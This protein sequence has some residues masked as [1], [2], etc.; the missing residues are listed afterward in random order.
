MDGS[1]GLRAFTIFLALF[2]AAGG[3]C[4]LAGGVCAQA[5]GACAPAASTGAT[6]AEPAAPAL[7]I[8]G[9]KVVLDPSKPAV[10]ATVVVR[11]DG[12]I[13]A[14]GAEVAVP[15]GVTV[16]DASGRTI[17]PAFLDAGNGGLFDPASWAAGPTGPGDRAA[18]MLG[19]CEPR[20]R[21]RLIS[22]GIAAVYTE[23]PPRP[24]GKG[25]TGALAVA[26][27]AP[28]IPDLRDRMAGVTFALGGRVRNETSLLSRKA[29]RTNV[30]SALDGA[31]RYRESW[32]K[33]EKEKEDHEK[34][35]KEWEE[36]QK[37]A[38]G[39]PKPDEKKAEEKKPEEGAPAGGSA[40]DRMRRAAE[41]RRAARGEEKKD[42]AAAGGAAGA[43]GSAGAGNA[44]NEKPKP[45]LP[46]AVDPAHEAVLRV[47]D[48][49]VPIRIEAHWKEDIL[50]ACE[51]AVSRNLR[52]TLLGATEALEVLDKVKEA[53]AT[54]VLPPPVVLGADPLERFNHRND[55]AAAL[56]RAG[57]P[58][59]F[60]TAGAGG[61][62]FDAVPLAA[63]LAVSFGLPEAAALRALTSGAARALGVESDFGALAPGRFAALQIL[64]GAPLQ[65]GTEVEKLVLGT[66][67]IDP[68]E[69]AR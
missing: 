6:A 26:D 12:R 33:F 67:A 14:V 34:K 57:V 24:G 46:P 58:V 15:A 29:A 42:G 68:R 18:D 52:L 64:N 61:W 62:R 10:E 16:I 23:M 8:T 44:G 65:P 35:L 56:D 37:G 13:A 36:K 31:K 49:K 11:A 9:G 51:L 47:L 66:K 69:E 28:A 38:G 54:V 48:R 63:R 19:A 22:A 3:V 4:A 27:P 53:D 45:P 25:A 40:R 59:A 7:A 17:A 39:A 21:W 5:G 50:A 43:A 1:P 41:A 20:A 32:K 2:L 30:S 55:L 60:M